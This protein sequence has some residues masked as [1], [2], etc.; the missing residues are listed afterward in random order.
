MAASAPPQEDTVY[1]R[2]GTAAHWVA[3]EILKLPEPVA[4]EEFI[5]RTAPNGYEITEEDTTAVQKYLDFV[6]EELKTGKYMTYNEVK[7]DLENVYPGLFG[8]CDLVL[9]E[10]NLKR[11]KVIDYKHGAGIPVE[12]QN[13]K[14]LLYYVL[15]AI[16]K[17]CAVHKIDYLS[18]FGWGK[19]FK[20]VEIIVVQP[21]CRHKGGAVRR[22]V[23][24][25]EIL[26]QFATELALKAKA[27]ANKNASLKTGDH[28]RFCPAIG[29]C[30][31]INRMTMDL[32]K[33]DFRAVSHPSNLQMPAP[34][35]LTKD[36]IVKLLNFKDLISEFLKRVEAHAQTL[37]EHG[38]EITGYKLVQ[39]KANRDWK[40][41]EEAKDALM[42]FV[43]EDDMYEKKFVSPAK[44]EK[45]LGKQQK[46][47][48]E[49]LCYK[50]DTGRTIAPEHD[51]REALPASAIQDFSAV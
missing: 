38:E 43:K 37:M 13:N 12:V 26:E 29:G 7:F 21:R 25:A 14:Q 9:L 33:V 27:T 17:L 50:P 51:P 10:S 32:A 46:K 44:A 5:G 3:D 20:E 36:E 47:I 31:E 18:L 45:L 30:P 28:C 8:T 4:A 48:V 49:D 23:V 11:L 16:N 2:Q 19:V 42:L 15:G 41:E 40:N 35:T 6:A 1:S 24:P 39:K 34:E 22:W